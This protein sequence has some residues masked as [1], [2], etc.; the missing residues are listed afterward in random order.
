MTNISAPN[1][2]KLFETMSF[3]TGRIVRHQTATDGTQKL[4][5]DWSQPDESSDSSRL[6][7][8]AVD[9]NK[10]TECVMIPAEQR[11]TACISSQIGCPVGCKFCASGI[12]GLDGNLRTGQIVEQVH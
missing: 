6:P 1:R 11:K 9:P 10:Q 5:I 12:G 8:L 7:Q 2:A 3:D 4:L